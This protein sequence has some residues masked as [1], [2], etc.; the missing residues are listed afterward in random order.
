M[1]VV[2]EIF[3]SIQGESTHSGKPCVFIRLT[4]C[5]LR[6]AYCD[7]AYAYTEGKE[8]SISEIMN[9]AGKYDCKLVEITGG[10]PLLQQEVHPLMTR[11]CDEKYEV[12]LETS[13]SIDIGSVDQ[14]VKRIV[15]FKSPS[16]GMENRNLMENIFCLKPVDEVKFIIGNQDDYLW[17][18][19]IVLK[20][21]LPARCSVLMSVVFGK[22]EANR[23]VGWILQDKLTVRFQLQ[24]QKYIWNPEARGV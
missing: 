10:E 13:G 11:L 14:R 5:N 8:M 23:L 16:S 1:L 12:L 17:A 6:C 9:E 24:M 20:Y 7:T 15:D 4:N 3:F 19:S 22:L 18:K 2:N 21:D